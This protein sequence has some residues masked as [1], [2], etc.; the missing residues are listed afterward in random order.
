MSTSQSKSCPNSTGPTDSNAFLSSG[1]SLIASKDSLRLSQRGNVHKQLHDSKASTY[2][3]DSSEAATRI[4]TEL[5]GV[6]GL[7]GG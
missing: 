4:V 2:S 5:V 7:D 6:D 3:Y 1:G